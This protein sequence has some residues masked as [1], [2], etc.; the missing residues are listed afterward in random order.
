MKAEVRTKFRV[1]AESAE[2]R[3][4]RSISA[5]RELLKV[6][7]ELHLR[8]VLL[9]QSKLRF[10]AAA[11]PEA[12]QSFSHKLFE[13]HF[14]QPETDRAVTDRTRPSGSATPQLVRR[15]NTPIIF[16]KNQPVI[17]S[18]R[19]RNF[20]KTKTAGGRENQSFSEGLF[21]RDVRRIA[22]PLSRK[23]IPGR[24]AHCRRKA[25]SSNVTLEE[26]ISQMRSRNSLNKA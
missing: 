13:P 16:L 19:I 10:K 7:R 11:C 18:E 3:S 8:H 24:F 25:S 5:V 14:E 20:R 23:L 1:H 2:E 15:P 12:S 22:A 26:A 21:R 6:G 17:H 4:R 9:M